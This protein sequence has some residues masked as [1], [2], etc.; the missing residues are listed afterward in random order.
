VARKEPG[1]VQLSCLVKSVIRMGEYIN[2][3]DDKIIIFML[4]TFPRFLAANGFPAGLFI[5]TK[6]VATAV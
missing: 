4:L 5:A 6:V 1:V 3:V 2:R